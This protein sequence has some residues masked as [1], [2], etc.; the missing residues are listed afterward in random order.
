[1]NRDDYYTVAYVAVFGVLWGAVEATLGTILHAVGLP[2][3]GTLLTAVGTVIVLAGALRMPARRGLPLLGMGVVAVA[4]KTAAM[5]VLKINILLSILAEAAL[6]QAGVLILG[7]TLPGCLLGGIWACLWPMGQRIFIYGALFGEG[8][9]VIFDEMTRTGSAWLGVPVK[10]VTVLLLG[11]AAAH[12][13]LG[14][15]AGTTGWLLG[16]SLRKNRHAEP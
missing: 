5:G 11:L 8:L 7:Y 9:A 13:F 4:V 1:M 16:R 15:V 6:L 2:L 12:A 10:S 3:K 14:A